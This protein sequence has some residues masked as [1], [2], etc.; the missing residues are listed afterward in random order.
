[1]HAPQSLGIMWDRWAALVRMLIDRLVVARGTYRPSGTVTDIDEAQWHREMVWID[2]RNGDLWEET[3]F[4][5]NLLWS[6]LRLALP[7]DDSRSPAGKNASKKAQPVRTAVANALK[8]IG[9]HDSPKDLSMKAV[10][11]KNPPPPNRSIQ[12]RSSHGCADQ[13]R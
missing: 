3:G 10:A 4:E 2:V 7:D 12:Q 11:A 8:G 9:M 5:G 6:G 1:M 13:S